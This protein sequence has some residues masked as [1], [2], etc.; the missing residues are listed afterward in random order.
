MNGFYAAY[1]TGRA[2]NSIVLF[3]A[4]DGVLVGVDM[5]GMKYDGTLSQNA[6]HSFRCSIVYVVPPGTALITGAPA[7]SEAQRMPVE[8]QL[9]PEFW[10][11]QVVTIVTPLGPVNARFEK[12]RDL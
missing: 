9:P 2:G 11:G 7:P 3:V 4:R 8:F 5:G 12:I 1:V 10:N 6:D